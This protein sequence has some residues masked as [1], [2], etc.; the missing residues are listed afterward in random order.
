MVKICFT[1]KEKQAKPPKKLI[2]P[3]HGALHHPR[4]KARPPQHS[5][6]KT[7]LAQAVRLSNGRN[8]SMQLTLKSLLTSI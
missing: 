5:L 1:L 3:K 8:H 2:H 4:S 7:V 6:S